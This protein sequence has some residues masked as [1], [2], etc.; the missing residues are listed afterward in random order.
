GF[1][2]RILHVR[3]RDGHGWVPEDKSKSHTDRAGARHFR[4][5]VPVPGLRQD[6]QRDDERRR[7]HEEGEPCLATAGSQVSRNLISRSPVSRSLE[8]NTSLSARITRR[9]ISTRR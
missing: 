8:L 6:P 3:L 4:K 7:E 5:S 9:R 1:P 2:V